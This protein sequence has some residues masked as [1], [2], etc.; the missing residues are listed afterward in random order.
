MS[1]IRLEIDIKRLL[2]VCE[3]M[4]QNNSSDDWRLSKVHLFC[5]NVKFSLLVIYLIFILVYRSC[6][7]NDYRVSE[8]EVN[9]ILNCEN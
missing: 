4:A 7:R 6:Q 1:T 2:T 3:D 8:K 9:K 5:L